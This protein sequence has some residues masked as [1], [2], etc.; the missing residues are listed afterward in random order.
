MSRS[1]LAHDEQLLRMARTVA[2]LESKAR[3]LRHQL[4]ETTTTLRAEKKSL[5]AYAQ[6]LADGNLIRAANSSPM[7]LYGEK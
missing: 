2:R 4:K 1:R 7:R 3:A 5:R 6:S